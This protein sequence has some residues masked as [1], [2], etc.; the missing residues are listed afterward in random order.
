[1]TSFEHSL[2]AKRGCCHKRN[3]FKTEENIFPQYGSVGTATG[4]QL[5]YCICRIASEFW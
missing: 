1:M 5:E 2:T 4:N 3:D